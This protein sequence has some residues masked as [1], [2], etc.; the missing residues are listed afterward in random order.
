MQ[1]V[2]ARA[3]AHALSCLAALLLPTEGAPDPG[4][5][6]LFGRVIFTH[7]IV[8]NEDSR[9]KVPVV[10]RHQFVPADPPA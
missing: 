2:G 6:G 4:M 3:D 5:W 10:G 1:P 7:S 9:T 8:L